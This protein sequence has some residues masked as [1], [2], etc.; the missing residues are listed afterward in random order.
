MCFDF[1][2]TSSSE[3]ILS[4]DVQYFMRT[5]GLQIR[6]SRGVLKSSSSKNVKAFKHF[7]KMLAKSVKNIFEEVH[8]R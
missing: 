4:F 1:Y 6:G 7:A 8:I 5:G 3:N 2:Y